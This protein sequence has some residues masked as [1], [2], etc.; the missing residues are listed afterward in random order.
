MVKIHLSNQDLHENKT[1]FLGWSGVAKVSC[2]LCHQGVQLRVAYSWARPAVLVAGKGRGRMF[3]FCFLLSFLFFPCPSFI[4][5]TISFLPLSGRQQN[6]SQ[7][8][9][10]LNPNSFKNIFLNSQRKQ[11]LWVLQGI[12]NKHHNLFSL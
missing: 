9:T 5:S 8:L 3:F 4:S 6:D 7:G 11:M 10:S 1:F 12:P 2:M